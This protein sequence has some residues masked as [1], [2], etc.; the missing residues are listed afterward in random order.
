MAAAIAVI[1]VFTSVTLQ[2]YASQL[3]FDPSYAAQLQASTLAAWKTAR[4]HK[5]LAAGQVGENVAKSPSQPA[6]VNTY[7]A[8]ALAASMA[9]KPATAN[10][11]EPSPTPATSPASVPAASSAND[12]APEAA[13]PGQSSVANTL[14]VLVCMTSYARSAHGIPGTNTNTILMSAAAAK[15]QDRL[16]CGYSHTAC[17]RPFNYWFGAKGYTGRCQ[18]E[19][20]AEGQQTPS[21]VFVDWMNSA[22]HRANILNASYQDIGVAETGSN[23]GNLWVMELGGCF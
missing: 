9:A 17:G 15:A 6:S 1:A 14:S 7:A 5:H 13:C 22:G 18:A 4:E 16:T 20:I 21:E 10:S 19:N 23:A 2:Q 3:L 11:I 8:P 12:I